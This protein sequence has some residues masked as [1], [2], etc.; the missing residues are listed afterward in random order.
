[1]ANLFEDASKK[2]ISEIE[3]DLL[4]TSKKQC[5]FMPNEFKTRK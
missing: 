5:W 1:M 2:N 4:Y 3:A